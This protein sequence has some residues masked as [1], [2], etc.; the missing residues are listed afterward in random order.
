MVRTVTCPCGT[1]DG[2][3]QQRQMGTGTVLTMEWPK[4][5]FGLGALPLQRPQWGRAWLQNGARTETRQG[6]KAEGCRCLQQ[7]RMVLC[8]VEAATLIPVMTTKQWLR[9]PALGLPCMLGLS[10]SSVAV[11]SS[12]LSLSLLSVVSAAGAALSRQLQ[13]HL[14]QALL[15]EAQC[16]SQ[17]RYHIHPS[18]HL[19]ATLYIS[20]RSFLNPGENLMPL[21]PF[22]ALCLIYLAIPTFTFQASGFTHQHMLP[23]HCSPCLL[24]AVHPQGWQ[25][26]AAFCQVEMKSG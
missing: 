26:P 5:E 13:G 17:H 4:H 18:T 14:P 22:S 9:P 10:H 25:S 8:V 6:L 7:S 20:S 2:S 12:E 21:L 16:C 23:K 24:T 11:H 3:A 1:A 15:L 19:Q